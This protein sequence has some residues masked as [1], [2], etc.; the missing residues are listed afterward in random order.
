MS[1][2]DVRAA[3]VALVEPAPHLRWRWATT[4]D[5]LADDE[6][7]CAA[8]AD[9]PDALAAAVAASAA[10]RGS[11]DPQVLASL[12]WQAYAYRVAG[13][14]LAC[15]LLSGVAPDV[16]AERTAVGIAR[17]RPS[18][19]VYLLPAPAPGPTTAVS[20]A[21][22]RGDDS[23]PDRPEAMT[24]GGRTSSPR[25]TATGS[26]RLGTPGIAEP[27]AAAD[28]LATFV[29]RL[30]AGH[31]D[32]VAASLRA[33]HRL[34]GP[35]LWGNVAAACASAVGAVHAVAGPSWPDRLS[36]F[37]SA[38]PHDL[39]AL[40]HWRWPAPPDRPDPSYRRTTCCLWWKTTA[41]AGS[42]CADCSLDRPPIATPHA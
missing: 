27:G 23:R 25:E 8:L 33:R 38:A 32:R 34:G 4:G 20:A 11:D 16:R 10:G 24:G 5:P 1:A 41:A 22:R 26:H 30:F 12:W 9:D 39:A 29:D 14:A 2:S 37:L 18:A 7:S 28:D 21:G 6:L 19:V 40:G 15:W 13:T 42:L 17:S 3:L 31:L 35:L 36:A